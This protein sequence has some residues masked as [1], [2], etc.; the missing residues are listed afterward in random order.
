MSLSSIGIKKVI[1]SDES[2]ETSAAAGLP[3]AGAVAEKSVFA[4]ENFLCQMSKKSIQ[5]LLLSAHSR[6]GQINLHAAGF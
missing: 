6:R 2:F 3:V 4:R 5:T 1:G